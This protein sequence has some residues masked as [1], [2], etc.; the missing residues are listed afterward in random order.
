M[1]WGINQIA[2]LFSFGPFFKKKMTKLKIQKLITNTV[3]SYD[4]MFIVYR[5]EKI[6]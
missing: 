5:K 1:D 6:Q 2:F 4:F 3:V